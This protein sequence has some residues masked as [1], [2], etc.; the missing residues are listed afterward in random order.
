MYALLNGSARR[1]VTSCPG[2]PMNGRSIQAVCTPT[3]PY[4]PS[5]STSVAACQ[6]DRRINGR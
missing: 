5:H 3:N 4:S 1:N 2:V 6:R